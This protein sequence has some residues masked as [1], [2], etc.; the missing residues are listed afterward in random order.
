[1]AKLECEIPIA[2][3]EHEPTVVEVTEMSRQ[4]VPRLP[5]REAATVPRLKVPWMAEF[6]E[7]ATMP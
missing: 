6:E 2:E 7:W 1:M 5:E 3:L 4:K